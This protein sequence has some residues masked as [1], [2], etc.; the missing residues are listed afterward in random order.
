M[1]SH[2][3]CVC[4]AIVVIIGIFVIVNQY[5]DECQSG[6]CESFYSIQ[7]LLCLRDHH[8]FASFS[9][10]HSGMFLI[11]FNNI[12]AVGPTRVGSYTD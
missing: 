11:D 6:I 12:N 5:L 7:T 4:I 10:F 1:L 3:H 8:W 2:T 9:H